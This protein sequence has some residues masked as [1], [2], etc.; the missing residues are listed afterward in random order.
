[1]I[2]WPLQVVE[3]LLEKLE[4]GGIESRDARGIDFVCSSLQSLAIPASEDH[5]GSF[6]A[7]FSRRFESDPQAAAD[8]DNR[9][10]EEFW[11]A[12]NMSRGG[13]GA[14]V[15]SNPSNFPA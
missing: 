7:C 13:C 2:H 1:M 10:S 15:S 9:L 6:R 5:A 3:E 8:H 11:L 12:L 14:H 4:V